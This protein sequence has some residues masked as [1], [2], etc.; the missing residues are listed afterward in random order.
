M[1]HV[2]CK[3][4]KVAS[5]DL[6]SCALGRDSYV[7]NSGQATYTFSSLPT[8]DSAN[9]YATSLYACIRDNYGASN[10]DNHCH[11]AGQLKHT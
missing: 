9:S 8:G 10:C 7:A 4:S 3:P 2:P 1:P 11:G 5:A 6:V